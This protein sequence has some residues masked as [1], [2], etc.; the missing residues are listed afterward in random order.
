MTEDRALPLPRMYDMLIFINLLFGP[1]VGAPFC[2]HENN[3]YERSAVPLKL[4]YE[5]SDIPMNHVYE[6]SDVPI[7]LS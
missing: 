4:R 1:S 2:R 3:H 6:H 7:K 5:L